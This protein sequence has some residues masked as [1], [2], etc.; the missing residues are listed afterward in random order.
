MSHAFLAIASLALLGMIGA[1]NYLVP[2]LRQETISSGLTGPLHWWLDLS[3]LLLAVALVLGT[4]G[5][6]L[7]QA[8]ATIAAVALVLTAATNTFGAFVDKIT[9]GKHSLWHSRF[10]IAVFVSALLLQVAGDHGRLWVLTVL[11]VAIP[12]AIYVYFRYRETTIEGT[13]I[14]ASPAAE[15]AFVSGLCLWLVVW[16]I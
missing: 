9:G 14:A 3:Y 12:A 2:S 1:Q 15:K 7:M 16:A 8:L 4:A 10:T 13:S 11:N 5:H 6:P